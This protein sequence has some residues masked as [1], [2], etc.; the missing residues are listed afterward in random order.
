MVGAGFKP[1][2]TLQYQINWKIVG[3][4]HASPYYKPDKISQKYD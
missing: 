3:A 1:A 4:R 2:P